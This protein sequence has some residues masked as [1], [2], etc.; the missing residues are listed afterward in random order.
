MPQFKTA[1]E[2]LHASGPEYVGSLLAVFPEVRRYVE[3]V[4]E[5]VFTK[6]LTPEQSAEES[7]KLCNDA[8]ETYDLTNY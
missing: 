6:K 3:E 8:I 1:P 4:T 5:K 2:Q 7:V